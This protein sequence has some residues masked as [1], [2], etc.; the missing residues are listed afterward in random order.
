MSQI[1]SELPFQI[2]RTTD[3]PPAPQSGFDAL[4]TDEFLKV[5]FEELA[6]Q[7]PLAPNDTKALIDQISQ[8]RSIESDEQIT[9]ELRSVAEKNE[10]LIEAFAS[11]TAGLASQSEISTAG[12][13]IGRIVTTGDYVTDENGEVVLD[14]ELNPIPLEGFVDSVTLGSDGLYLNLLGSDGQAIGQVSLDRVVRVY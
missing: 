10:E 1:S 9:D 2:N 14:E 4:T 13:M 7:D 12:S 6:N 5:I 3:A 8:I 11:L